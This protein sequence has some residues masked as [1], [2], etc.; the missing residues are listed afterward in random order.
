MKQFKQELKAVMP[1]VLSHG[2]AVVYRD[3]TLY[4]GSFEGVKERFNRFEWNA[5]LEQ[6]VDRVDTNT[7]RPVFR[8]GSSYES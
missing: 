2:L 7:S 3:K 4:N 8:L 6:T 5:M 1:F